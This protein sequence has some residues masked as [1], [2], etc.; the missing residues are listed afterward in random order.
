M[1]VADLKIHPVRETIWIGK[2]STLVDSLFRR[3]HLRVFNDSRYKIRITKEYF[4]ETNRIINL[5]SI[6]D[7]GTYVIFE[8]S[9]C[10]YIL[11]GG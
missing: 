4:Y 8:Y 2:R 9:F 5:V 10:I 1:Y 7:N 11:P 6:V 3:R